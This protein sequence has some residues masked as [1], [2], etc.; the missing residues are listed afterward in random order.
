M[1]R[2]AFWICL[3]LVSLGAAVIGTRY[4]PDAFSIVSLDITMD[5]ERALADARVIAERDGSARPAT[6]RRPPSRWTPRRRRSSSSRR[7]ARTPSRR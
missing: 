5:R 3:G 4:F 7:A 1:K 2:P 6:G